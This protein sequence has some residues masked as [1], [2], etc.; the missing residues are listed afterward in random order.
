MPVQP[1]GSNMLD[2]DTGICWPGYPR[3]SLGMGLLELSCYRSVRVGSEES[4]PCPTEISSAIGSQ[5]QH[6]ARARGSV[7]GMG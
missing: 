5:E 2:F 4:Q 3:R 6:V 1:N 7:I